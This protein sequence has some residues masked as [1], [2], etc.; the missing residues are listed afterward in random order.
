MKKKRKEETNHCKK[1]NYLKQKGRNM[2][3]PVTSLIIDLKIIFFGFNH[4]F[5]DEKLIYFGAV[6]INID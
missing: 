5:V 1:T 6:K 4:L 3:H 2:I